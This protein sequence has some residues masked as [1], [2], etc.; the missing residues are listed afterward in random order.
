MVLWSN[1]EASDVDVEVLAQAIREAFR[2]V[3]V[4]KLAREFVRVQ[5]LAE[6]REVRRY[7]PSATYAVG[8]KVRW[9]GKLGEVKAMADGGN[10]RQGKF[11]VLT[12]FFP[13]GMQVRLAAKAGGEEIQD[14]GSVSDRKVRAIVGE[15]G[16]AIRTAI[17]DAMHMDAR[18]VWFEYTQG[19][20][21]CLTE[22]LPEVKDEDLAKAFLLLQG[23]L[24][25]GVLPP[26]PTEELVKAIWGQSNDGSD[27][28]AK[29]A[30]ALNVALQ[31]CNDT[32]WMGNGW[33][34]ES[35]WQKLQ[36]RQAIIGPRQT[37]EITPP[38]GVTLDTTDD[39][40]RTAG[41]VEEEE[42]PEEQETPIAED[43]EAWRR[44]R[45]LHATF[46]LRARHYYGNY[47]PLNKDMRRV[48]PPRASEADAVTFYHRFGGEQESFQAWVDWNQRRILGSPQM[49][50]AFYDY[51]IY[52][53][54]KL[55]ISHRGNE[56]EYDIRTKPPTKDEPVRI[57]RVFF[58]TDENGN[59]I[60]GEDGHPKL[61]YEEDNEPRLY[62]IADEVFIVGASWEN[63]PE[64]F[65]EAERVGQGYFGLMYEVCCE[66]WEANGRK[67]LYVTADELFQ[68]IH[69]NRRLVTSEATI[70]W[71]LWR[72]LAFKPVGDG[73]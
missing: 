14:R 51:G 56:Q 61:E 6:T 1:M 18:F 62:E 22:M 20:N 66:W 26:R 5:L 52:P 4:N 69:Y 41:E 11:V 40:E 63:L 68:E 7:T 23:L 46:T 49:Y 10:P 27:E 43:L 70:P 64:L 31:G 47:L 35:E 25:D 50:Q 60:L 71:E 72:R 30:F 57:R 17:K 67:P 42:E 36:E 9:K 32:R 28:Y 39:D 13:D 38:E 3:H 44:N 73:R 2:P 29:K 15:Y 53:G 48:F 59:R 58:A 16:L 33:A 45:R 19:E 54:A 8:D 12:L 37:S 34:L 55:V 21:W 65:A 24:V